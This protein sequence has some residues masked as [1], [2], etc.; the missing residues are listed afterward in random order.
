MLVALK[1]LSGKTVIFGFGPAH[2]LFYS[3]GLREGCKLALRVMAAVGVSSA[4]SRAT[5][6]QEFLSGLRW[7]RVPG[8]LTE[9][10]LFAARYMKMFFEEAQTIYNSQKNRLGYA[11]LRRSMNSFGILAG[12]LAIRA[13][14]Q[15][16]NTSTA[17]LQRGYDGKLPA[18]LKKG[19]PRPVEVLAGLLVL[20]ALGAVWKIQ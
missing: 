5:P 12:S 13:F 2:V 10:G 17:M 7:F 3:E 20:L 14:D 9:V 4:V 6:F 8:Q 11:G 18:G 19:L 1:G 16:K 15:A